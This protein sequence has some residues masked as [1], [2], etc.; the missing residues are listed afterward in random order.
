MSQLRNQLKDIT[1]DDITA[2]NIQTIGGRVYADSS[3]RENVN[4]LVNVQTAWAA[5]HIPSK[6]QF[7]PQSGEFVTASVSDT[8][9]ALV[10]PTNNEV[11]RIDAISAQNLTLGS[12]TGT[13]MLQSGLAPPT[14]TVVT[15][16]SA[17]VGA[18]E[19]VTFTLPNPIYLDS[20]AILTVVASGA[21]LDYTAF[22]YKV[23]Q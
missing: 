8:R 16:S 4:D 6:G 11:Y 3:S 18:G 14:P 19:T 23:V 5:V 1:F 22:V 13:I 12:I 9:A 21:S 10:T 17:S 2:S 7:I 20:N 15:I